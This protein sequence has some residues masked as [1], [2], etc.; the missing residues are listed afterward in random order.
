MLFGIIRAKLLD[1]KIMRMK[2][3]ALYLRPNLTLILR[4]LRYH[5]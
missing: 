2:E 3:D 1:M 4:R 5:C